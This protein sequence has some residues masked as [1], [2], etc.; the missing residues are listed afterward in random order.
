MTMG[1]VVYVLCALTSIACALMLLRGYRHT[2]VRLLFWSALCFACLAVNNLV[3]IVDVR[4]LP[5]QDLSALRSLP[6][7]LGIGLLLYGLIWESDA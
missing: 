1:L 7:L 4:I 5:E 6:S 2:R 3:L